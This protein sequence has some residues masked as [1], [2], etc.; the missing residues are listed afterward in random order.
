VCHS[1]SHASYFFQ[2][3]YHYNHTKDKM[4]S[5]I[6]IGYPDIKESKW[7]IIRH[8]KVNTVIIVIYFFEG[9]VHHGIHNLNY[10]KIKLGVRYIVYMNVKAVYFL[11]QKKIA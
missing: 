9:H 2:L 4:G 3:K 8:L 6:G 1:H 10:D 11:K 7:W 5:F